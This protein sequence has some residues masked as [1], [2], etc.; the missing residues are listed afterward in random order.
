[1][2]HWKSKKLTSILLGAAAFFAVLSAGGCDWGVPEFTLTV[3]LEEG[4]TGIPVAGEY[5]YKEL[6]TVDFSYTGVNLAHTVEVYLND[7]IRK[8]GSGSLVMFNDGYV[9]KASLVDIRDNWTIKMS[10]SGGT[11]EDLEFTMQITGP[12]LL[13]GTFTDSEGH[14]GTWTAEYGN[15]ILAYWDW[16]FYLLTGTVFGMGSDSG[17]FQGGGYSGTW[18]ATRVESTRLSR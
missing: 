10:Y 14:N 9:L 15:L 2:D 11:L 1:M 7:R 18:T 17:S 13:E 8:S 4:V 12:D 16:N 3:V 5:T 6:S